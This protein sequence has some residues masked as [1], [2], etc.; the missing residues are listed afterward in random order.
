MRHHPLHVTAGR[1]RAAEPKTS[2]DLVYHRERLWLPAVAAWLRYFTGWLP[3]AAEADARMTAGGK[4]GRPRVLEGLPVLVKANI[5][6]AGSL[7]TA[8][9]PL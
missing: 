8:G 2:P 7:T 5:D 1:I 3:R 9:T 6:L 4:K